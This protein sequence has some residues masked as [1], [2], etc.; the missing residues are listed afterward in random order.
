MIESLVRA[1]AAFWRAR[2]VD[3]LYGA[4]FSIALGYC[5]TLSRNL[6]YFKNSNYMH[7]AGERIPGVALLALFGMMAILS[8]ASLVLRNSKRLEDRCGKPGANCLCWVVYVAYMANHCLAVF[9]W[10][11]WAAESQLSANAYH[12]GNI[13]PMTGFFGATALITALVAISLPAPRNGGE[14]GASG[15]GGGETSVGLSP[16]PP[17]I[18]T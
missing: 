9:V 5:A 10:A 8:L 13:A 2:F 18:S 16:S 6:D 7:A 12:P 11:S 14:S 15:G 3:A 4:T 1:G 17:T